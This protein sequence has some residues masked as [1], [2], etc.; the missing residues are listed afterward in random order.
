MAWISPATRAFR[1]KAARYLLETREA[2]GLGTDTLGVDP[3]RDSGLSINRLVL[4]RP[5]IVLENLT[6]LDQ[7]PATGW[8]PRGDTPSLRVAAA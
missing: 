1:R 5:R 4:E 7:L 8:W 6:R 3:G 2:A